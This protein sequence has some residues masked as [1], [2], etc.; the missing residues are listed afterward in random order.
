MKDTQDQQ[1]QD[2]NIALLKTTI[3]GCLDKEHIIIIAKW[4]LTNFNNIK[5]IYEENNNNRNI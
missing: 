2:K 3:L 1:E 4:L 5:P